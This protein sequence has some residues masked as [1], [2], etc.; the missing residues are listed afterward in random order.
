[1][2]GPRHRL[3]VHCIYLLT[4][5]FRC[6][7]GLSLAKGGA[8]CLIAS[9]L[10]I[11]LQDLLI[12]LGID[13]PFLYPLSEE[14]FSLFRRD[15][16]Q[17]RIM[18]AIVDDR[19]QS[20]MARQLLLS[21]R[22]TRCICGHLRLYPVV[23]RSIMLCSIFSVSWPVLA[24]AWLAVLVTIVVSAA[25]VWSLVLAWYGGCCYCLF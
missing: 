7:H 6:L 1:M 8:R 22:S 25:M 13:D 10:G 16:R 2:A 19:G 11:T 18:M 23:S 21:L 4:R 5:L 3:G 24:A 20:R 15:K 14:L 9:L 17:R 12:K